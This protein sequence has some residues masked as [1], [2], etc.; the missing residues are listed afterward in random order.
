MVDKGGI[1]TKQEFSVPSVAGA[2]ITRNGST[3]PF[4]DLKAQYATIKGEVDDA[5]QSVIN[6][7]AFIGGKYVEKFEREF[8]E[9]V[10]AKHCIGCSCGTDALFISVKSLGIGPG[11]EVLVPANTFIATAEAVE[12]AGATPVFV[13]IDDYFHMDPAKI[14]EKITS[15]TKAVIVVHLYGQPVDFI[16]IRDICYK[17]G[18]YIIEDCAQSHFATYRDKFTGT[19]GD[20][21]A[22]SFYPAKNLGAFG[23]GGAVVTNNDGIA[24][25]ARKFAFHGSTRKYVHETEGI[26]SGLDGIQAAILSVKLKY[27]SNWKNSRFRNASLYDK[28]LMGIEHVRTPRIRPG[29]SHV[30]HLYVIMADGRDELMSYLGKKGISCG[31]HYPYALPFSLVYRNDGYRPMDFPVSYRTQKK[32]LSLPMY[33]ELEDEQIVRVADSIREFYNA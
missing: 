7:T 11:D 32:I 1:L 5:I 29:N 16:A 22:F 8:A 4:V 18:L 13:D 33:P 2:T 19:L 26:N 15:K 14:E 6:E 20:V 28:N 31:I 27:S 3:V 30:F 17:R 9:M 24:T 25:F 21:G 12:L 23:D 10:E